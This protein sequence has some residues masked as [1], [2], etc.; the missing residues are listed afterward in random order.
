MLDERLSALATKG[1]D[2]GGVTP[3][4]AVLSYGTR[5]QQQQAIT[6]MTR[7]FY[8]A[9]APALRQALRH[10]DNA[11]RVQAATAVATIEDDFLRQANA[12]EDEAA[13]APGDPK[14]LLAMA[15]HYDDYS[16]TGLLDAQR[17]QRSRDSALKA[18]LDY[19]RVMPQDVVVRLAIGRLLLR[20]GRYDKTAEWFA[21]CIE[22]DQWTPQMIPWYMEGLYRLGRLEDVRRLAKRHYEELTR[23]DKFP[24]NVVDTVHLWA[25]AE[26]GSGPLRPLAA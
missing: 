22:E 25:T 23:L 26:S 16:H 15:T 12:L 17:E 11:V 1:G 19:L 10:P 13:A 2:S 3:F 14:G 8:P 21:L 6:L 7:Q 20:G 24:V 9:F 18:Y 4:M 5:L